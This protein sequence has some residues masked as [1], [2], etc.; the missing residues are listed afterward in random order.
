MIKTLGI[1]VVRQY[2]FFSIT[3]YDIVNESIFN[4]NSLNY[5]NVKQGY[6]K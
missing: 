1:Y 4:D 6:R 3:K 5:K 2:N